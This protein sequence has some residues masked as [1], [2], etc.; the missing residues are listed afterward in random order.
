MD[1]DF[2]TFIRGVYE[3]LTDADLEALP[4]DEKRDL[5]GK[6]LQARAGNKVIIVLYSLCGYF[7]VILFHRRANI[8]F[9]LLSEFFQ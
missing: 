8:Y 9:V 6:F 3:E 2:K 4:R 5:Y 7:L 1:P